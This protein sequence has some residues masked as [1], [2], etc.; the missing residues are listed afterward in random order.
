MKIILTLTLFVFS[1]LSFNISSAQSKKKHV[2]VQTF[3]LI[4]S[5]GDLLILQDSSVI[6]SNTPKNSSTQLSVEDIHFINVQT[7]K[8]KSAQG[9]LLGVLL[10]I[11][12]GTLILASASQMDGLEALLVGPAALV[13][14]GTVFIGGAIAGGIIG[15]R[16][17][18]SVTVNIP[19]NG[20]Q[21]LYEKQK[22][23]LQSYF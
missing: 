15:A 14:G 13:L 1:L 8:S 22:L 21:K 3:D 7:K 11:I 16:I 4:K 17:G 2:E 9:A 19:I 20:N 6:L 5:K 10:G 18:R 23:Q 12:P